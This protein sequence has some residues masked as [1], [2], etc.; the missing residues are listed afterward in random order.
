[1]FVRFT[2]PNCP[3]LPIETE[4]LTNRYD[5]CRFIADRVS[6]SNQL[7][8][9]DA[10]RKIFPHL[11]FRRAGFFSFRSFFA[12]R[13]ASSFSARVMAVCRPASITLASAIPM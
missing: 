9:H 10:R 6:I 1:M 13:L 11:T 4:V 2:D 8:L 3:L 7:H 12:A 5:E